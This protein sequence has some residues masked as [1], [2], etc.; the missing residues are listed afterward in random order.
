LV[1]ANDKRPPCIQQDAP[2]ASQREATQAPTVTVHQIDQNTERYEFGEYFDISDVLKSMHRASLITA[3]RSN[4]LT[5]KTAAAD[6]DS[7]T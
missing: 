4:A 2:R 1:R 3:S 5:R 7:T 6:R